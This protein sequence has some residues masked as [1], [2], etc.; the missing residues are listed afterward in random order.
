MRGWTG[1]GGGGGRGYGDKGGQGTRVKGAGDG[2]KG[3]G[4]WGKRG[5]GT[6]EE[7]VGVGKFWGR[8][9]T[10]ICCILPILL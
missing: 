10:K 7:G 1:G 4:G 9:Y 5:W 8:G 3:G 2:D 6:G